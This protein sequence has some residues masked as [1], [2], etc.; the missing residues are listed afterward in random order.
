MRRSVLVRVYVHAF[1]CV[2]TF[3]IQRCCG[4]RDAVHVLAVKRCMHVRR[5]VVVVQ[6]ILYSSLYVACTL[7]GFAAHHTLLGLS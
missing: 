4:H 1:L 2:R 7:A 6:F 3:R 5:R